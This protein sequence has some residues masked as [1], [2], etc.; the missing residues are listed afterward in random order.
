MRTALRH[1]GREARAGQLHAGALVGDIGHDAL[2]GV[3]GGRRAQV[4]DVVEQGMVVL[5]ADR[6]DDG[7][8]CRG[9]RPQESL[10][11]EA[12]EGLRVAAAAGDDDHVD[13]GVGVQRAIAAAIVSGTQRSPCTAAY[14]VRKR[15]CG[16]RSSALRWTS[17][18]ASDCLA[19]DQADAVRE[20]RQRLLAGGVEEALGAQLRA[21]PLELLELVAEPDV[22]HGR[23]RRSVAGLDEVVGLDAAITWSPGLIGGELARVDD[24]MR[25][26][27]VA[28]VRG[29]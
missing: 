7:G 19:G 24:Q 23:A 10:V 29:P 15:T 16:Q 20:E 18:S 9:H 25:N 21:Q 13:V 5:V 1:P 12:E 26:E 2:R 22:A 14:V 27:I 11:A 17:F 4:G 8:G 3:G 28:S 6:A